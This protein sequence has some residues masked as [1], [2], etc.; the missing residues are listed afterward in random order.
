M[1]EIRS[2][3]EIEMEH[4]YLPTWNSLR[5]H[6]TPQ[7]LKDAKFGIYAH[8]GI[9]SVPAHGP[10]GTW[11]PHFMYREGSPQYEYHLK[12]YGHP[13][14]FGYKDFIPMF[15]A[16]K[17]DADEWAELFKS[18]GARFAGPVGE[19]HDGFAMWDTRYSN[20]K[21]TRMGPNRNVV[22]ELEAAIRKQDMRFLVALHHAENWWYFPHWRPEFDTSDARYSGLYGELH[23]QEWA[24]Q[25]PVTKK[26]EKDWEIQGDLQDKPSK[27]FLDMWLGK[28]KE[29]IDNFHPD[30]LYFDYGI[31][32]IQEHYKREMVAYYYNQALE[33]AQ[34]VVLTYKWDHLVPG[35]GLIDLELGRFD[36]LTYH[37]W[38]TDTTVDDG[39]GWSYIPDTKFKP[40]STLIHYLIDNVSKNGYLVLN[41]G[42]RPD[43]VIP[44]PAKELLT[45]I[46]KWLA[47]NGEAIYGTTPWMVYGEGP[48]QMTKAGYFMED[49][50]VKY[51]AQDI[52]FTAK[53]DALYAICLGCPKEPLTIQSFRFLYPTEIRSINLLGAEAPV[54][55]SLESDGLKIQ[56]PMLKPGEPAYVF[57]IVRGH[58]FEGE[59]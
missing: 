25:K 3:K 41:V 56:P 58:P 39:H 14:K 38:I 34:E 26:L 50:E 22:K 57:K 29:V 6:R 28:T 30:M 2:S 19:H 24:Q 9:Y 16:E 46:G 54:Q 5:T 59:Y 12:T 42:P 52:R 10:N 32:W 20:W 7:W 1:R 43:G 40:L 11:Y 18:A 4:K 27:E 35:S 8:W 31:R 36:T 15:T 33:R 55:W 23:N 45:G 49:Q 51:T 21:A 44:D 37:D 48:T 17:F 47:V 13:S 53:D